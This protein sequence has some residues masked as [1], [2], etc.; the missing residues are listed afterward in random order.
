MRTWGT[1]ALLMAV[2]GTVACTG[3]SATDGDIELPAEM[4]EALD[5]PVLTGDEQQAI[6]AGDQPGPAYNSDPPT[7]GPHADD[8]AD[9]GVYRVEIPDI[10][11]VH[12]LKRGTIIVQYRPTL[13]AAS[14]QTL[15][16]L[17]R[18][19]GRNII[20][21]PRSGLTAPIVLTAWTRRL[22]LPEADAD[23]IRAFHEQF[24]T[25]APDY[26]DCPLTVTLAE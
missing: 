10:Y 14:R 5:S 23:M 1:L 25:D 3:G 21:A 22:A 19:L 20:V 24:T 26:T 15:E 18:A 12:S 6:L 13:Q 4:F 17:T 9:C 7:S 8:F 11:Q 2:T 16:D